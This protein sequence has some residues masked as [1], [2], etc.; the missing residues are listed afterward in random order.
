MNLAQYEHNGIAY[1]RVGLRAKTLSNPSTSNTRNVTTCTPFSSSICPESCPFLV[2]TSC[3]IYSRCHSIL[4]LFSCRL[5]HLL[6]TPSLK[7]GEFSPRSRLIG[8][9]ISPHSGTRHVLVLTAF[10]VFS[11]YASLSHTHSRLL[12]HPHLLPP[13]LLPPP[14]RCGA[15]PPTSNRSS[16][17]HSRIHT[18]HRFSF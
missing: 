10:I 7:S 9:C 15:F 13:H 18:R 8:T 2:K 3:S 6:I 11:I 5:V 1:V 16:A 17:T 4:V 12:L 14:L